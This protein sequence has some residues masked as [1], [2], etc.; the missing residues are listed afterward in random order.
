MSRDYEDSV[1]CK[2]CFNRYDNH[3]CPE[4]PHAP[5]NRCPGRVEPKWP[6]TIKNEEK[7]GKLFDKR[8]AKFWNERSTTFSPSRGMS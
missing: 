6:T 7:A 1:R 3:A 4:N 5:A 2:H 8:L